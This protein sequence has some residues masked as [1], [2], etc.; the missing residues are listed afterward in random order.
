MINKKKKLSQSCTTCQKFVF[1]FFFSLFISV[2]ADPAYGDKFSRLLKN[3]QEYSGSNYS[4]NNLSPKKETPRLPELKESFFQTGTQQE[5]KQVQRDLSNRKE[6]GTRNLEKVL[7]KN[8]LFEPHHGLWKRTKD[9]TTSTNFEGLLK[10]NYGLETLLTTA[11]RNNRSIKKTYIEATASLEKYNQVSNLD[12]ILNQYAVFTKNLQIQTGKPLHKKSPVMNFPF[13]GML[14]LK[15]NI[16]DKEI[17]LAQLEL[18]N[19]VQEVITRIREIYH[20]TLYLIEAVDITHE[21]L[22]LLKRLRDVINIIYTTGKSTLNDVLK[23]QMEIDRIEN[24]LI[25]LEEKR[26]TL[27]VQMNKLLDISLAF[28]PE[29]LQK[30]GP[31]LLGYKGEELFKRGI[32]KRNAIKR[33]VKNLERM[34][35][36]I[37]MAE[38]KFYPD[39]TPGFSF[40]QNRLIRQVGTDAPENPFSTR[41]KIRGGNWFGSNDAYIR[42]TKIKYKALLEKLK[43]LKNKTVAEITHAIYRYETADRNRKLYKLKLVPKSKITIATTEA[44]YKTG[45]VD[46]LELIDSETRFLNYSLALKKA[47][48][49]M[50]MEAAKIEKLVG[51]RITNR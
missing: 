3:Y 47:I 43:E 24:D 27:Q 29:K 14:A 38:K 33:T 46:F 51:E 16:V 49:D 6:E 25:D 31:I 32:E 2:I 9:F 39:F 22:G 41:P 36:I 4:K 10:K 37:K 5:I 20:K 34:E 17:Q 19:V 26:K 18:E 8:G 40:F 15:G 12:E 48:R 50:N 21:T 42:E 7:L 11:L 35:L 13:P 1:I 23:I 28:A 45:K 30:V 44:L